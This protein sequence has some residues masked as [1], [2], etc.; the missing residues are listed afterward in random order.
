[1][2]TFC[3]DHLRLLTR[4]SIEAANGDGWFDHEMFHAAH[5]VYPRMCDDCKAV[6]RR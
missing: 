3:S 6:S 5:A 1:M 2:R 4:L